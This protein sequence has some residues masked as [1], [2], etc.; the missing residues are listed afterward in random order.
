MSSH[1]A[2]TSVPAMT[3]VGQWTPRYTREKRL[4]AEIGT[5]A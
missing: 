3:S 5:S 2:P 1:T 4:N